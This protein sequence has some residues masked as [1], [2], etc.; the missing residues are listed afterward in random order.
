M[1]RTF[2][3]LGTPL[4]DVT[5]VVLDLETT[6]GSPTTNAIT[7]IGAVKF[8]GGECLGTFQTL[9]NPS[10]PIPPEIV[11]LTGITQAMVTPAPKIEAVLPAFLEFLADAVIVGHNVRFDMG[12]LQA[13]LARLG[14]RRLTNKVVDT[15][16]L[17]RRLVRDE[18]PNCT[19]STLARYFRTSTDPCHRALDDAKA[20]AEVLHALLERVGTLGIIALDDLLALPTTA[21]HP[22]A[23]KLRWVASLPRAAGVYVFRDISGRPLYVGKAVDLRRRVRSYFAG[24]DR[25][26][27]GSLLREAQ[28]LDHVV[29]ANEL[30]AEVLEVRMIQEL[31]PRFNRKD[32]NPAS[33]VYVKLT[34]NERFPRLAIARVRRSNDGC[35]YLGPLPSNRIARSVIEAIESALPLRRCTARAG[36]APTREAPCAPAQLRV[37]SCPCSGAIGEA[38]YG[39]IVDQAVAAMTTT[40]SIVLEPLHRRMHALAAAGRFEEAA[41]ARD[42]ASAFVRAVERQRRLDALQRADRIEIEIDGGGGALIERGR[43]VSTWPCGSPPPPAELGLWPP[44]EA[45]LSKEA[46][47]EVLTVASWVERNMARIRL[48]SCDGDLSWPV[49]RLPRFEPRRASR[50]HVSRAAA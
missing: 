44:Q 41:S 27:I 50:S 31:R 24:D 47:A 9:V 19:L 13:N 23:A 22:Q 21:A 3:D 4:V 39:E 26:K 17:A 20:T 42:R 40:P 8:R 49:A 32:K 14:Y 15:C 2:D 45:L 46:A 33:S 6:G 28:S 12:F 38:A 1:Q 16:G 29:C 18:V 43:L 30:H 36:A 35:V 5:F 48:V 10:A 34:T 7:E 25:R 37:A 11:Y